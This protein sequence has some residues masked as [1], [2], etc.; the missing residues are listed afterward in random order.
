MF[1]SS[2]HSVRSACGESSAHSV[3][4]ACSETSMYMYMYTSMYMYV[5]TSMYIYMY[6]VTY[7]RASMYM[8]WNGPKNAHIWGIYVYS[9]AKYRWSLLPFQL[10]ILTVSQSEFNWEKAVPLFVGLQIGE[11]NQT[12]CITMNA[13]QVSWPLRWAYL[14]VKLKPKLI[15]VYI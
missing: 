1:E 8:A 7:M 12:P 11:R 9:T 4:S 10:L 5:Y 14:K 13:V 3:W 15:P 6:T 2:A